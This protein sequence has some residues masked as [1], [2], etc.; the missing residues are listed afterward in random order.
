[1]AEASIGVIGGSG[2]YQMEGL[3]DVAGA[4]VQRR[5]DPPATPSWSAPWKGT[6][7][8][9]LPR[10]GRG[11][12]SCPASCRCARTSGRSKQLGVE[13]IISVS[14]C[15]SL[16]EE[17][18]PLDLVIP[19][20]LI[21]RTARPAEH[22]LRR[23]R[24]RARRASPT[25]FV[26]SSRALLAEAPREPAPKHIAAAPSSSWRDRRS[27]PAPSRSCTGHGAPSLIGMTALPEAKLAREA[28]ICYAA[29]ACVDRL[30]R[31]A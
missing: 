2:F 24:R 15:G 18:A 26:R 28:E 27:R 17:I 29:V 12:A 19:D 1:M 8:A 21:D 13:R 11:H 20:Q 4:A 3:S 25:R 30:R 10:H 16:R 31:L 14:A 22:L 23:G 9:F 5:S 6:R 7:V